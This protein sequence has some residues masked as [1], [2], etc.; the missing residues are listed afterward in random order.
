MSSSDERYPADIC[1][2]ITQERRLNR[3]LSM[4]EAICLH[5]MGSHTRA[6]NMI[7]G[8]GTV[9]DPLRPQTILSINPSYRVQRRRKHAIMRSS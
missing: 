7:A 1:P 4:A 3:R 8:R 6:L 2:I 9:K 5:C